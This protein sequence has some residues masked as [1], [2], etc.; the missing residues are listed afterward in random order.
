MANP[1]K[2][3]R[4]HLQGDSVKVYTAIRCN[5]NRKYIPLLKK[6]I[7]KG[8]DVLDIGAIKN[9]VYEKYFEGT[10]YETVNMKKYVKSTYTIDILKEI[11]N[12]KYDLIIASNLLEHLNE[13]DIFFANVKKLLKEEGIVIIGVPFL[14]SLHCIPNDYYRFTEYGLK[15]LIEKQFNNFE[16]IPHG[17]PFLTFLRGLATIK[18]LGIPFNL[19]AK[20]WEFVF[21]YSDKKSPSGYFV[22]IK[23]KAEELL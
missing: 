16:I 1:C 12:K 7:K 10:N 5:Y 17:N 11:P 18:Y 19:T 9:N 20:F 14:Y 2:T 8:M 4:N 15:Y 13:P 6:Y 21:R 22:I 23:N 3:S